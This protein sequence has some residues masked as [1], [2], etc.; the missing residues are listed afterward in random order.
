MPHCKRLL[1]TAYFL[2]LT[3]AAWPAALADGLPVPPG[4]LQ[5]S[6]WGDPTLG[7]GATITYSYDTTYPNEVPLSSFMPAG[8]QAQIA[9]AL[10]AW[11]QVANLNFVE[12]PSGGDLRLVG[13]SIDGPGYVGANATYPSASYNR[14]LFDSDNSWHIDPDGNNI[15]ELAMHELGHTLGLLHPPGVLARMDHNVSH[16]YDGLLPNDVAGIQAIYGPALGSNPADYLPVDVTTLNV[17]PSSNLNVRVYAT[18]IFDVS[19]PSAITGSLDTQLTFAPDGT[20]NGVTF[21][22]GDLN[23]SDVLLSVDEA[24][25]SGSIDF[26]DVLGLVMNKDWFGPS[27][28]LT[29]VTAGDFSPLETILGLVG[30]EAAYHVQSD[31]LGFD[32]SGLFNFQYVNT[33]GAGPQALGAIDDGRMGHV[34]RT[35]SLVNLELPVSMGTSLTISTPYGE[36]PL[37]IETTGTIYAQQLVPEPGSLT[38]ASV[39]LVGLLVGYRRRFVR[40][41]RR[42]G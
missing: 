15:R 26:S 42:S 20:P 7:T 32:E 21:Y 40:R 35:S 22:G 4:F 3:M 17:L 16:A 5:G 31:V 18:G 41:Q 13:G 28:H 6:K 23:F 25:V 39:A 37:A 1:V 19:Q 11:S 30:G 27:G 2:F 34:T 9:D 10:A 36:I 29:S 38:L 12:V 33:T 8:Y 24:L 14:V